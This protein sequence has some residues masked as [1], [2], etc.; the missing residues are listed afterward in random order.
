MRYTFRFSYHHNN[1]MPSRNAAVV[2]DNDNEATIKAF[3]TAI[4][5][6]YPDITTN[7]LD[8]SNMVSDIVINNLTY[9]IL[10]VRLDGDDEDSNLHIWNEIE[11]ASK[12][13]PA[14][15]NRG[16]GMGGTKINDTDKY[17]NTWVEM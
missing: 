17:E 9:K 7:E 4:D 5:D 3:L 11:E 15:W 10:K 16:F 6:A 8:M 14:C 2:A 1:P 12:T 13:C